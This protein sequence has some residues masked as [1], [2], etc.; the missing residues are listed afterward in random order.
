MWS[1][2]CDPP[3]KMSMIFTSSAANAAAAQRDSFLKE[4]GAV[5]QKL[6]LVSL[7]CDSSRKT[8]KWV[9]E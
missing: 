8:M 2:C 6:C 4:Y 1:R 3:G 7:I 5:G 9:I